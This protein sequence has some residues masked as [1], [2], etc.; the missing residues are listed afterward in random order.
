MAST[1]GLQAKHEAARSCDVLEPPSQ[2]PGRS[3]QD[4]A[5]IAFIEGFIK[6]HGGSS[7]PDI[8]PADS[9]ATAGV[10]TAREEQEM[11]V[12]NDD[13]A[14]YT[15]T[16]PRLTTTD[17]GHLASPDTDTPEITTHLRSTAD[18]QST[19]RKLWSRQTCT[20][21]D[22]MPFSPVQVRYK[23]ACPPM[24]EHL[25]RKYATNRHKK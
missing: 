10:L 17:N 24:G 18:R 16:Q 9:R 22:S 8:S 14:V 2:I 13:A 6:R 7:P 11:C 20:D 4:W 1:P 19:F 23:A 25:V 5:L 3:R 15:S 21:L 12:Q